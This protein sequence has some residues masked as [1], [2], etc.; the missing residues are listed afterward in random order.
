MK[1]F[2]EFLEEDIGRGYCYVSPDKKSAK[3]L[4]DWA[5]N[6]AK[7]GN[8][9]D[10]SELHCTLIYD[11]RNKKFDMPMS[12]QIY[13]GQPK[14]IKMLG[15]EKDVLTI[16]IDSKELTARHNELIKAGYFR[17]YDSY[18]PH[19]SLKTEA[20]HEDVVRAKK[21]FGSLKETVK[22]DSFHKRE[23]ETD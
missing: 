10:V 11:D 16:L 13:T 21:A 2:K 12:K 8:V 23:M 15:E 1:S 9:Y 6:E 18:L 19:V 5:V 14:Q 7:I 4:I 20:T 22:R 17:T 3:L